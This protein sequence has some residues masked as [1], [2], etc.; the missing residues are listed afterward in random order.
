MCPY[1]FNTCTSYLKERNLEEL[2]DMA[3][4]LGPLI[5]CGGSSQELELLS[6]EEDGEV[7]LRVKL[8]LR[9][10]VEFI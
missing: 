10:A 8:M 9:L 7:N 2:V 6:Y 5:L 4:D 1:T 3:E